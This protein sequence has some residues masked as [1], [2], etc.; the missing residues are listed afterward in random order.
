MSTADLCLRHAFGNPNAEISGAGTQIG[1]DGSRRELQRV[2]YLVG[3]LP[4]V[5]VRIIELFGPLFRILEGVMQTRVR[6]GALLR[7]GGARTERKGQNHQC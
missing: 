5:T 4:R 1:N 6:I 7:K 2:Q 3:L